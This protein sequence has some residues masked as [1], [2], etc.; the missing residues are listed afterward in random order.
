MDGPWY[1]S[2]SGGQPCSQHAIA[3]KTP[4][5]FG[6]DA[7]VDWMQWSRVPILAGGPAVDRMP[8]RLRGESLDRLR[9]PTF[10]LGLQSQEQSQEQL[11]EDQLITDTADL[12]MMEDALAEDTAAIEDVTQDCFGF[13][14]QKSWNFKAYNKSLSEELEALAKVKAVISEK[15]GDA[16]S[17]TTSP[18]KSENSIEYVQ[19]A[20]RVASAMHAEI[21]NDDDPFAKVKGFISDMIAR[22]KEKAFADAIHNATQDHRQACSRCLTCVAMPRLGYSDRCQ[23]SEKFFKGTVEIHQVRFIDRILDLKL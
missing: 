17:G 3:L 4:S 12:K 20:S 5:R 9:N 19:I 1:R 15:T 11:Y 10:R 16:E 6:N 14:K 21:S 8:G 22:L 18:P 2:A 23:A 7:V 13:A